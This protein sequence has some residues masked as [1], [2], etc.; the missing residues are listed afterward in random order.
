MVTGH[1]RLDSNLAANLDR[2]YL[3]NNDDLL[4]LAV[5]RAAIAI[6]DLHLEIVRLLYLLFFHLIDYAASPFDKL[7]LAVFYHAFKIDH[8][9]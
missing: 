6:L 9:F 2:L 4:I 1:H 8:D 3:F 7:D 5:V